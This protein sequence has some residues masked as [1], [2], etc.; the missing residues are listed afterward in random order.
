MLRVSLKRSED[1]CVRWSMRWPDVPRTAEHLCGEPSDSR[2]RG[3]QRGPP[4]L[5]ITA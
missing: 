2:Y 5:A 3:D 1:D 4:G